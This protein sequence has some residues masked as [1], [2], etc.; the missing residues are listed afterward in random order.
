MQMRHEQIKRDCMD[1]LEYY[2]VI[3]DSEFTLPTGERIDVVGYSSSR[4][5]PDIGIEVEL[6]SNLSK[7]AQKLLNMKSLK[8]R[9][10]VTEDPNS[11]SISNKPPGDIRI[12]QPHDKDTAFEDLIRKYTN[13]E[14]RPWFSQSLNAQKLRITSES[15]LLNDFENEMREQQLDVELAK[16]IIFK[17]ALG[18]IYYGY[19]RWVK[20][21]G[22]E[23][24]GKQKEKEIL[25]LDARHFLFEDRRGRN[26]E[27]G[28]T[29][30]YYTSSEQGAYDLAKAVID[31]RV[32]KN[33]DS[34][35]EIAEKYGT[36][37]IVMMLLGMDVIYEHPYGLAGEVNDNSSNVNH[38]WRSFPNEIPRQLIE[39]YNIEREIVNLF[40]IY[41]NSSLVKPEA[42]EIY[43]KIVNARLGN[44]TDDYNSNGERSGNLYVIPLTQV[45]DKLNTD[46]IVNINIE[47][48]RE[49]AYWFIIRSHNPH[50]PETLYDPIKAI[51]GQ[52]NDA[53]MKVEELFKL[54]ITSRFIKE[55]PST[56]AIYDE[57]RFREFCDQKMKYILENT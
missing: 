27:T 36:H 5:D 49:Y 8:L 40:H 51:G 38:Y 33:K 21:I 57:N 7:D 42:I 55:G 2:S 48:L 37:Y 52:I 56:I 32:G 16:D 12:V 22:T 43:K 18:G 6:T 47:N 3:A 24:S 10:I 39:Q 26:Y 4:K 9:V 30:I 15:S 28:K 13:Q 54:G 25:Y 19:Y 35:Q 50:V 17:S 11:L 53:E 14:K 46:E 45:L 34:L 23:Y 1:I 29:S 41:V 44:I 31:E 20:G